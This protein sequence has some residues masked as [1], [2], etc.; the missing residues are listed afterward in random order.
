M[1]EVTTSSLRDCKSTDIASGTAASFEQ[2]EVP[3]TGL[4]SYTERA[5]EADD[6]HTARDGE[7][8]DHGTVSMGK[9]CGQ[10]DHPN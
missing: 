6:I 3:I 2:T 10:R 1:G 7:D 9:P 4:V 5:K 8:E